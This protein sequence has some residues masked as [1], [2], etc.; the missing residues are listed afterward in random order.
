MFSILPDWTS[1]LVFLTALSVMV[2]SPGP[3]MLYVMARGVVQGAAAGVVSAL[4]I[5]TGTIVHT[6][7]VASGLTAL[8]QASPMAF[9][10]IRWLGAAYL[11]YLGIK[12][13]LDKSPPPSNRTDLPRMSNWSLFSQ[14]VIT[15]VLNPKVAMFFIA[16]LPQFVDPARGAVAPQIMLLGLMVFTAGFAVKSIVGLF[17]GRLGSLLSTSPLAWRIQ[18][19]ISASVLLG[20]ALRLAVSDRR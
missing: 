20:L 3:D 14:G 7:A 13:L 10:V 9:E 2:L 16:F 4:G 11:A 8:L 1:L 15:N 17:S 18:R 12:T 19:Y 5:C 6:L